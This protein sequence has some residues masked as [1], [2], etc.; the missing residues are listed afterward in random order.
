MY[1]H[2]Y[3]KHFSITNVIKIECNFIV[4]YLLVSKFPKAKIKKRYEIFPIV[5][6]KMS[7]KQL[8]MF[9]MIGSFQTKK[10]T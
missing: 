8:N 6:L 7:T 4:P 3:K 9:L 2:T 10:K 5:K 1:I